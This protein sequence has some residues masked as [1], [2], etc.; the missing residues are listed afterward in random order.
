MSIHVFFLPQLLLMLHLRIFKFLRHMFIAGTHLLW[1]RETTVEC[2]G[3]PQT[4]DF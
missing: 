2:R 4:S 3:E 1:V